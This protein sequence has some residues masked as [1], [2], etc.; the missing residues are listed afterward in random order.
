[1]DSGALAENSESY[2]N[3][4]S[5]TVIKDLLG[6]MKAQM[7]KYDV[8]QIRY[9][10]HYQESNSIS[11]AVVTLFQGYHPH[12]KAYSGK[13]S[14]SSLQKSARNKFI[15]IGNSYVNSVLLLI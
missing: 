15:E 2:V 3:P 14:L 12:T 5:I 4:W 6:K 11:Y 13:L 9:H 8:R 7:S 1:M 10:F